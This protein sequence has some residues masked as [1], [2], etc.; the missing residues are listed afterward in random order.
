[1]QIS[2]GSFVAGE[3]R[4]HEIAADRLAVFVRDVD[5][6]S[7]R[8]EIGD[9]FVRAGFHLLEGRKPARVVGCEMKFRLA[10][11]VRGTQKAVHRGADM[12]GLFLGEAALPVAIGDP[13][14][15]GVPAF[16]IARDHARSRHQDFADRAAAFLGLSETAPELVGEPRMLRP[17]M[18]AERLVMRAAIGGDLVDCVVSQRKSPALPPASA[19]QGAPSWLIPHMSQADC[20]HLL[21]A[22]SAAEAQYL[23][24]TLN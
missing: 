4:A 3:W 8:I 18:P 5:H 21:P 19:L 23:S 17:V 10:V 14:P 12:A 2:T 7:G 13:H 16:Q 15:F 6:L 20:I 1:M 11:V 22:A 24:R 9:E